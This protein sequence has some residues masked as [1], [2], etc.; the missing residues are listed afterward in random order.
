M[1]SHH[2]AMSDWNP[3]RLINWAGNLGEYVKAVISNIL[4]QRQHPEQAY[5]TCLGI[6]NL[7]KKYDK[8]RLNKACR[9]AIEFQH[10]SYK[11]IR[12]ILKNKTEEQQLDCFE[13]FPEHKNIR[14]NRYY[15]L[16]GELNQ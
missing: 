5:K 2:Q 9:R 1:P 8:K 7:A 4:G 12:N 10:Y 16:E 6:L 15:Q 13:P 11:G 14:G 3:D